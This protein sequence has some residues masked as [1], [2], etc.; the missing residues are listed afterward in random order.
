[1]AVCDSRTPTRTRYG[2]LRR[3]KGGA[4]KLNQAAEKDVDAIIE[5]RARVAEWLA[6]RGIDMWQSPLPRGRI[7]SWVAQ[8]ALYVHRD[9]DSL[10]GTIAL[11]D[12]DPDVWGDDW[13]PAK[14]VHLLMV[15]RVHAGHNLG[16]RTLEE[17][18]AL[19]R[20]AGAR[21]VRLDAGADIEPLQRWYEQRG[22]ESVGTRTFSDGPDAFVVTLRQKALV[23]T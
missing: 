18:E 21:Y 11:L 10:V 6:Q 15:D 3:S 13:S 14:Y 9:R 20:A 5:L 22:Y 7:H 1:M 12:E 8:H 2:T 19:A 17:A 23:T 16:G 4:V